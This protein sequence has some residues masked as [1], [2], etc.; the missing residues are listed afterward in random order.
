MYSALVTTMTLRF[1][2]TRVKRLAPVALGAACIL[3]SACD[4]FGRTKP[5][6]S[7]SV[8]SHIQNQLGSAAKIDTSM[9]AQLSGAFRGAAAKALPAVVQITVTQHT[10]RTADGI[11]F[12]GM[13]DDAPTD[14]LGQA[15]GSGFVIDK[16][17]H[18]LTN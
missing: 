3:T 6:D 15:F 13:Q 5:T 7:P 11:R 4:D 18:I 10:Q 9:T 1:L 12:Q 2:D 14:E 8:L 17:G 16:E